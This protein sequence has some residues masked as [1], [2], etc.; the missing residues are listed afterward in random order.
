MK[1]VGDAHFKGANYLVTV[2][3]CILQIELGL[4]S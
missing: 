3:F 2:I 1:L 4:A